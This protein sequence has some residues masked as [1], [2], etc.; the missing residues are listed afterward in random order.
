VQGLEERPVLGI[1]E[2]GGKTNKLG[3]KNL[4]VDYVGWSSH[5]S[6]S[7]TLGIMF[8]GIKFKGERVM[9]EPPT[10]EVTAQYGK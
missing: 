3:Q 4:Y 9:C 1:V 7:W 6:Y 2:I 5:V 10:Q 8:Y